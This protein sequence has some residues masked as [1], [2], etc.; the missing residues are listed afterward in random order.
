[1]RPFVGG[2]LKQAA[3][4]WPRM[5]AWLRPFPSKAVIRRFNHV[6]GFTPWLL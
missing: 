4:L 1:M 5:E 2:V 6:H 3:L